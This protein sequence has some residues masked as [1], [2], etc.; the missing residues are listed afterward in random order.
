MKRFLVTL[1]TSGC[2]FVP[3]IRTHA[4]PE[5]VRIVDYTGMCLDADSRLSLESMVLKCSFGSATM[6]KIK[7]SAVVNC[8][9][10]SINPASAIQNL[11]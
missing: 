3:L 9:C 10:S 2:L 5:A 8:F 1:L 6:V 4:A 7:T 11:V